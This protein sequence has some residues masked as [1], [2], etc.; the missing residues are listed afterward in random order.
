MSVVAGV[1]GESCSFHCSRPDPYPSPRLRV[2]RCDEP[3]LLVTELLVPD[4]LP[5]PDADAAAV[6]IAMP[7]LLRV[8]LRSLLPDPEADFEEDEAAKVVD[9][10]TAPVPG[11]RF[12]S[13]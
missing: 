12:C 9:G 6:L 5:D 8:S 13:S 3:R 7:I 2:L 11:L 4:M 1:K 10:D